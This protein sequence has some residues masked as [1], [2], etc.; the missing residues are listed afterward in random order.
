MNKYQELIDKLADKTLSFGCYVHIMSDDGHHE[1]NAIIRVYDDRYV[2]YD[3]YEFT[4]K[5]VEKGCDDWKFK[6]L[7]RPILIGDVLEKIPQDKL[8]TWIEHDG[9][10]RFSPSQ[11][12]LDMDTEHVI[13]DLWRECG[14]TKSLQEIIE[15]KECCGE[16][17]ICSCCSGRKQESIDLLNF[18]L[19]LKLV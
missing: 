19:E 17:G 4:Y 7:G 2:H 12:C 11:H 14:F 15:Y 16:G 18:I 6:I 13:V 9:E 5:D 10:R 1:E 8:T 3:H